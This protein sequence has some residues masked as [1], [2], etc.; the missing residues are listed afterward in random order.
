MKQKTI[1]SEYSLELPGKD[2]S[3][4]YPQY[5]F[6]YKNKKYLAINHVICSYTYDQS[7]LFHSNHLLK[8]IPKLNATVY[9]HCKIRKVSRFSNFS[10]KIIE[11]NFTKWKFDGK[12]KHTKKNMGVHYGTL[13]FNYIF[14]ASPSD[15]LCYKLC[16]TGKNMTIGLGTRR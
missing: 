11:L 6:W 9:F 12:K 4:V 7:L 14:F 8:I 1:Y 3:N 13:W 5:M 16:P 10:L 2:N 15:S